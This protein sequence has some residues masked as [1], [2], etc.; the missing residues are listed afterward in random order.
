VAISI[1]QSGLAVRKVEGSLLEAFFR[2]VFQ[3][4]RLLA[5]AIL[6]TTA[7]VRMDCERDLSFASY[8]PHCVLSLR[9]EFAIHALWRVRRS[10]A[11]IGIWEVTATC[12]TTA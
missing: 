3:I 12:G 2:D 5:Q 8:C 10:C 9:Q 4:G 11:A 6:I 1:Q 7:M